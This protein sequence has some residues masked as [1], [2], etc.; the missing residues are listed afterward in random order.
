MPRAYRL[1]SHCG[2]AGEEYLQSQF[3]IGRVRPANLSKFF[4][5]G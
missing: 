4:D 2:P 1:K 3:F 5:W